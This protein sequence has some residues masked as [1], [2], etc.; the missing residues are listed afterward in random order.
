VAE[1][2]GMLA[3]Q[4]GGVSAMLSGM[5]ASGSQVGEWWVPNK[6]FMYSAQ[7]LTQELYP[8]LVQTIRDLAG[9]ALI[10]LPSSV[11]DFANPVNTFKR[12]SSKNEFLVD[13]TASDVYYVVASAYDYKS[14]AAKQRTLLWRT[15]MTV[16][17]D[18][19][20]PQQSLPTLVLTA[21]PFFG[22]EMPEAETFMKRSLPEGKV[23]VGTPTVV[24]PK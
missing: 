9:G 2:L 21:G 11:L 13:Q 6:H 4:V 24:E 12:R 19:V 3:A 1:Q 18:G 22:K 5:E 15:R 16:A 20:S 8:R 23:E 10:M 7:V 14:L 17:S